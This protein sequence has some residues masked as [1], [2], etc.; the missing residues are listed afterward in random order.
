MSHMFLLIAGV[1]SSR[2]VEK[3]RD[4]HNSVSLD[5]RYRGM[6]KTHGCSGEDPLVCMGVLVCVCVC[7][8]VHSCVLHEV[9]FVVGEVACITR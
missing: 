5:I 6:Y 2:L 9:S 1:H 7:V 4:V 8:C 3:D